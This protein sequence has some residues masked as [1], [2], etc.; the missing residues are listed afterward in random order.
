[1]TRILYLTYNDAPSGIYAGQVAD[2]CRFLSE[3]MKY[4]VHLLAFVSVRGYRKSR[5]EIRA[6]YPRATVLPMAPKAKNWRWNKP[7]LW[8]SLLRLRPDVVLARGP[9]AASMALDFR[10]KVK[11]VCFDGRGA[12]AAELNEYDVVPDERVKAEVEAIERRVVLECDARLAVTQELVNY[13]KERFGYSGN[14]HVVIPCTL[15]SRAFPSAPSPERMRLARAKMGLTDGDILLIYSGSA[16]GWQS[17]EL[18]DRLLLPL[19][20]EHPHL[21]VLFLVKSM[22]AMEAAKKYPGR[23]SSKWL[24]PAEVAAT[25]EAGDYGWLVRE[26]STTNKVASPVKFA[27]YLAAGLAVIISPGLGDYPAF[28][29]EHHAGMIADGQALK[30]KPVSIEEKMRLHR[31]AMGSFVKQVYREQYLKLLS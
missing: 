21:H 4:D 19:M 3:E 28:V 2:V 27:E 31:L 15:N 24:K 9:F 26:E 8:L 22:P 25:L 18:A 11:K 17:L 13:W 1:M 20:E 5:S 14:A 12:Y 16:A 7:A 10:E 29:R 30:L 23:V 6:L